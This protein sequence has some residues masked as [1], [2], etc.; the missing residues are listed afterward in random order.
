MSFQTGQTGTGAGGAASVGTKTLVYDHSEAVTAGSDIYK[1]FQQLLTGPHR[2]FN[3]NV[4][5]KL[6]SVCLHRDV[7]LGG[8]T[9][10]F[11]VGGGNLDAKYAKLAKSISVKDNATAYI[12]AGKYGDQTG[13]IVQGD[14]VDLKDEALGDGDWNEAIAAMA[15]IH[16]P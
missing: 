1:R 16:P 4:P 2:K 3:V 7:K 9:A 14:I 13:A 10:C 12:Y 15:V 8:A 11:G 5:T 6:P